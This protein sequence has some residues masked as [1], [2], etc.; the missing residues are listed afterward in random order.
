MKRC[1]E[2]RRDYYDDS[3]LYCLDD[4]SALLEGPGTSDQKTIVMPHAGS[5]SFIPTSR[6][7]NESPTQVFDAIHTSEITATNSVAVLP[8]VN[9]G[10]DEDIG[11]FS[12]GLAEE[13]LNVLS[14]IQGLR[15][16]ARTSAFS[17]KG[18][19]TTVT[20]IGNA[21]HVGAV[22]EGSIRMS[23]A[24]IRIAVQLVNVADGYHLWSDTYD[25]TMDDI[26][27]VQ[28]DIAQSVVG[29]LRTRLMGDQ[30][31]A[32]L[33]KQVVSDVAEAVK[34]RAAN[35]E[36][37]RLMLLGRY[38][39]DRT[40]P[41]DGEKAV[42]Y[43]NEALELDP[44]FALCWAELGRAHSVRAGKAWAPIGK[45]FEASREATNKALSLEPDL[46]EAHAQLGRIQ[47]AYDLDLRA[48][49]ASYQM[50]LELAP[51]S[52]L[53]MDGA[54]V[55]EFKLGRFDT[56]LELSRRVLRQDPLSGSVWHNLG[57]ICHAAGLLAEAEKAF[58]RSL[59]LGPQRLMGNAMLAL[60]LMD[61]HRADEALARA[62]LEP[63]KFWRLWALTIVYYLMGRREE[64]D[65]A[66]KELI[67]VYADG[68]AY[69]IA[70]ACAMR[71]EIDKAIEWLDRAAEERDAGITHALVS[72]RFRG[73]H[74]HPRW[75]LLMKKIGFEDL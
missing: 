56:A 60:V 21:L 51:G 37:Q 58:R 71:G 52:S 18:K 72:P 32:E 59:D 43:F 26:F 57:I 29:E 14:K 55:L 6:Y 67:E 19:S 41:E 62:E 22:V 23:G 61:E 9:F 10:N 70:E 2:C 38:F 54:S 8:F 49:A 74:A 65:A 28:D 48:A 42:T 16:A 68:D 34:G 7:A 11:Y 3:L 66:V 35:P 75:P 5:G 13:L 45:G 47:A 69:Q 25:R 17:F 63:D 12:D 15:V 36:A 27:A 33:N 64:S 46:A 4:G 40:T 31:T 1:P 53:V 30:N 39:L 44:G 50:A 73:L 24:R 20:E